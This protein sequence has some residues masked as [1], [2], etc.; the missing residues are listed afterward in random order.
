MRLVSS[1]GVLLVLAVVV[2]AYLCG[3]LQV[4]VNRLRQRV[5]DVELEQR[6]LAKLQSL[7]FDKE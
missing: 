2:L 5:D 7:G 6:S 3:R 1:M 4:T